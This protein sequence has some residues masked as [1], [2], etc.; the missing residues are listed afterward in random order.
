MGSR[1]LPILVLS[2]QAGPEP[3]CRRRRWPPAR[4]TSS[5]RTISTCCDPAGPSG[6]ALPAPGKGAEPGT[7]DPSPERRARR[8]APPGQ[9]GPPRVG[10]RHLRVNWRSAGADAPA[11]RAA[12]PTT[13]SRSWSSSTSPPVS[14]TAWSAGS[15]RPSAC[16]SAIADGRRGGRRRGLVRA[17][18]RA[19]HAGCLR[20]AGS[21]TGTPLRGTTARP[22]TSCSTSIAAT[23]GRAGVAVV[24]TGMGSDGAAGA[25]CGAAPGRAGHRAGRAV[26]GGVRDAEVRDQPRG[27]GRSVPGEDRGL[28]A[29]TAPEPAVGTR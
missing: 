3:A 14:P 28:P 10:D 8:P 20:A 12:R 13:R 15:T 29:G 27:H 24:L 4:S 23:A 1:P 22:V 19:P 11:R 2:G 7:R 6:A 26:L 9:S 17:G 25:G 21:S 18:G 16:R 5:P